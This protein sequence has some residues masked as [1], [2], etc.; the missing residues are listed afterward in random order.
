MRKTSIV[1][2]AFAIIGFVFM[3][4]GAAI[5]GPPEAGKLV[6]S[7]ADMEVQEF[8]I[9]IE[10][11]ATVK[12]LF[13]IRPDQEDLAENPDVQVFASYAYAKNGQWVLADQDNFTLETGDLTEGQVPAYINFPDQGTGW[14]WVRS[15]AKD[16][17][18]DNWVWIDEGSE[19]CRY[20]K[21]DRPGYEF[22]VNP[23]TGEAMPV[24]DYYNTRD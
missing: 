5:A 16:L 4:T 2:M 13:P 22:L 12:F 1:L 14:F 7:E 23:E 21:K 17:E 24:P 11:E 9:S 6:A 18:S 8:E 3:G 15:W 10:S 19:Y 20:D